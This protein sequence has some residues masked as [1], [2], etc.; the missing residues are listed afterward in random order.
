MYALTETEFRQ[1]AEPFLRQVFVNNNAFD[2]PFAPN[3]IGRRIIYPCY[4]ELEERLVNA[5]ISAAAALGDSGCYLSLVGI[6]GSYEDPNHC[7]IPLSEFIEAYAGTDE[8]KLI[9]TR[10]KM[11]PYGLETIIY[12]ATGKWGIL[13][14]HEMYGLLG[15]SLEFIDQIRASVAN[16][17]EQVYGFLER[18]RGLLVVAGAYPPDV[19]RNKWLPGLLAHVYGLEEAQEI[20]RQSDERWYKFGQMY[21][22]PPDEFD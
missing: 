11:N 16:L 9:G 15:G 10:L 8:D 5:V 7:Y 13:T 12:S 2:R 19:T 21:H 1:E 18:L 6:S 3:I 4:S 14:S 17:D 22:E 20:L